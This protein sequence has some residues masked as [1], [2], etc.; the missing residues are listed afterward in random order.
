MSLPEQFGKSADNLS[1]HRSRDRREWNSDRRRDHGNSKLI[2]RWFLFVLAVCCCGCLK[3]TQ[4]TQSV[5]VTSVSGTITV[6]DS[7]SAYTVVIG[8]IPD[9]QIFHTLDTITAIGSPPPHEF[10]ETHAISGPS[11][12][13]SFEITLP[14]DKSG[15]RGMIAWLDKDN[16]NR[17]ELSTEPARFPTKTYENVSV[18]VTR[19]T[20]GFNDRSRLDY[21]LVIL[22]GGAVTNLFLSQIGNTGFR[23]RF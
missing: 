13:R 15:N 19:W 16:N 11:I 14:G 1:A 3:P 10:I 6:A 5:E 7:L 17:L 2:G 8:F 9:Y 4:P 21:S 12:S 22:R 20:Y 18:V 23:F